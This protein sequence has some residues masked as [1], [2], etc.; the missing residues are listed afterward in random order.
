M[1]ANV[2]G[3]K[4]A[5]SKSLLAALILLLLL[6]AGCSSVKLMYGQL[7]WWLRWQLDDY[8]DL[9]GPQQKQLNAAVDEF[10]RWHR[11]TQLPLYADYLQQLAALL[12]SANSSQQDT[13][14]ELEAIEA[15]LETFYRDSAGKLVEQLTPL[16]TKLNNAQID[17]LG[18]NLQRERE[19]SLKKW[20]Q[21]GSK[22]QKRRLKE[23]RKQSRRWLGDL[24]PEQEQWIAEWAVRV[25]FDPLLRDRQRQLWQEHFLAA[26]RQKPP[27][28]QQQ[29]RELLLDPQ[30]LWP[31]DYAQ[32]QQL[33]RQQ[34]LE[35]GENILTSSTLA[36]RRHLAR[37]LRDYAA[38]FRTL[39]A[40]N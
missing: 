16:I 18:K 3:L 11:Q 29:L 23:M 4:Q 15:Q 40:Q 26:L 10:H 38:D 5:L 31:E 27:G 39:Y 21:P 1:A 17:K 7:D 34:T 8:L 6:P 36:Q 9:P 22:R 32:M 13:R 20:Q 12:E 24:T 2:Q 14:A 37:E 19:K 25:K 28:Y 30:R 35:L 33:W